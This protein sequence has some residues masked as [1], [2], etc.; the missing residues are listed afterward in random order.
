M[1]NMKNYNQVIDR[2]EHVNENLKTELELA[3][4]SEQEIRDQ[5][6]SEK[7]MLE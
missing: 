6:Q 7:R 1:K 3:M 5:F 2:M 4:N